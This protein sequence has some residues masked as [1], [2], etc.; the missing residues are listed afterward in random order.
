MRKEREFDTYGNGF[1]CVIKGVLAAFVFALAAM[2]IFA[3]ILA[4]A[5]LSD[6]I[7]YPINQAIKGVSIAVG[8]VLFVKGEKGWLKGGAIALVFTAL[9]YPVFS[10]IGGSFAISWWILAEIISAFFI[11]ALG[12]ILAVNFRKS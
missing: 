4:V 12:G 10:A 3:N 6:N 8:S 7:I 9:A 1:F 2:I 5:A 11:G